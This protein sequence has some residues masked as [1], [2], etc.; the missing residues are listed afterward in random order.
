MSKAREMAEK[1]AEKF[2]IQ[3]PLDDHERRENAV[4]REA[5]IGHYMTAAKET[6]ELAAQ[7]VEE[8]G[9]E[10]LG[11]GYISCQ[12]GNRIAIAIRKLGGEDE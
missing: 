11:R 8:K 6:L 3:F 12:T 5:M 10:F 7:V 1:Y 9:V 4:I 2:T